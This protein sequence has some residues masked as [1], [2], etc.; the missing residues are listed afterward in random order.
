MEISTLTKITDVIKIELAGHCIRH[1]DEIAHNLILWTPKTGKRN[2]NI[3]RIL[4][5]D[6]DCEEEDE[7]RSLMM[8]RAGWKKMSRSGR[9]RARLK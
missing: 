3:C 6:C 9:A 2:Q 7:I 8:D 5:N 4:K 1:N